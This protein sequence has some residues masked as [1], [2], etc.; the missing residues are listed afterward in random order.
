M[1]YHS[2]STISQNMAVLLLGA[3][4]AFGLEFSEFL[5]VMKT[6]SLTLSVSGMFKVRQ[7][8]T[9]QCNIALDCGI[10]VARIPGRLL[11]LRYWLHAF[12]FS[13]QY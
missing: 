11:K 3:L 4:I 10:D 1:D 13:T 8:V 7:A 2:A 6:S 9:L 12:A 5:L